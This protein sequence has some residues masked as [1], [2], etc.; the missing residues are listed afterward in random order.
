MTSALSSIIAESET[1][2]SDLRRQRS[3]IEAAAAAAPDPPRWLGAFDGPS[4]CVVAE[5]KRRS[6]SAGAIAPGLD[7][8]GHARSYAEGG[9]GAISVLT[10]EKH[11]GGSLTDLRMVKCAVTV[12]LLRKDFILDP[13]QLYESRA[14]GAS[15][16]LLIVR[17]LDPRQLRSLA[18]LSREL[19]LGTL[20]EVLDPAELEVALGMDHDVVG[21]NSR[22]LDTFTVD[23]DRV[24]TMLPKI[25]GHVI[26]VAESGLRSRADVERVATWG[27]DA[28]LIGTE[29]AATPDPEV[30]VRALSGVERIGRR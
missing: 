21:V 27:A 8:A 14:A 24:A 22:D 6:P 26:A 25:P 30:A 7:P 12:P 3:E 2:V 15:A 9:A 29:L 20:V 23:L 5:V 18:S 13:I 28:V 1:R 10:E 16:V 4:V 17:V 19:G 11:F